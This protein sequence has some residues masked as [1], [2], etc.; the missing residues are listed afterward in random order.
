VPEGV[1]ADGWEHRLV[2]ANGARFHLVE[3]GAGPLV[4]FL[5]GF[6]EFWWA[7]RHQLGPVAQAGYRCVAMDLRGYGAS[8]KTPRGYDPLTLAGDVAG[9]I[10]SLGSRDA[11]LV[12]HGWGAYVAWGVAAS[13]PS[14]VAAL[15]TMGAPHPA[16]LLRPPYGRETLVAAR[17]VLGMQVPWLPERRIMRGD[18]I[19]RH[20]AAWSAPASG[21][22]PMAVATRYRE[23]L[24]Q[25][26]S[27]HCALEYH[28]WLFRSRLRADGRAF[29]A[30]VRRPLQ[31][32]VLQ[33]NG[34]VDPVVRRTAVAAA[35][36]YVTGPL[37][38]AVIE[39]AGHFPHEE[40][41]D[42]FTAALLEWLSGRARPGADGL[43]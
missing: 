8:D 4:L 25:W 27:P 38:N 22:P 28:R 6:P 42:A 13:H 36:R 21:F 1:V 33:V 37:D 19:A 29:A 20:L 17:H 5:H 11:R 12:G 43:A 10:R 15:C 35:A 2:A 39:G 31:M 16:V 14:H 24:A 41:P 9:V 26:P 30:V 23:A 18:Y 40:A 7:W 32:P 3:V 34:V